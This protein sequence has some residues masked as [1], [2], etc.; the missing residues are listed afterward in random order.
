M[1]TV[2]TQRV[3]VLVMITAVLVGCGKDAPESNGPPKENTVMPGPVWAIVAVER[4]GV[5]PAPDRNAEPFTYLYQ[6][7]Q[8][9]VHGQTA[10][11]VFLL[12]T[13][14]G[15]DGWIVRAQV[16]ITGDLAQVAVVDAALSLETSPSPGPT[17]TLIA[18]PSVAFT[19]QPTQEPLPT[20]TP[21]QASR[22]P[23]ATRTPLPT[24]TPPGTPS[25]DTS[26]FSTDLS[27]PGPDT[28]STSPAIHPGSP[29]PLTITLPEGWSEGHLLVPFRTLDMIRDVPLT[30]Y[31]GPLDGGATGYI[32]LFWGFPSV[33]SPSGEINLWADGLQIL[34]GSLVSE[35]CN[36]GIYE[37]QAFSVGG[38]EAIGTY[39]QADSCDGEE[40]TAGWFAAL[41]MGGGNFVFFTAVEPFD[42]LP[43]Q[44]PALQTIL[45]SVVFDEE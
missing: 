25:P 37:Q 8:T 14:D 24:L 12:T 1:R 34:R 2:V 27:T 23:L 19:G 9:A 10:D 15:T 26:L 3:L 29:P 45:D 21:Q 42:A 32:Y 5:F 16:D 33:A 36:L 17:V 43:A 44:R 39:Y 11:G 22:T 30:I 40:D 4:A 41:Q 20:H 18:S 35:T 13:V 7:E 28:V 6:R 38:R 31:T